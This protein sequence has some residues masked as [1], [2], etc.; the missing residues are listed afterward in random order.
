M[1]KD[2]KSLLELIGFLEINEGDRLLELTDGHCLVAPILKSSNT[3]LKYTIDLCL[4]NDVMFDS[5]SVSYY[6]RLFFMM[7]L[8][9]LEI[10]YDSVLIPTVF[11]ELNKSE[12]I[13]LL[14]QLL[15]RIKKNIYLIIDDELPDNKWI[16]ADFKDFDLSFFTLATTQQK[17]IKIYSSSTVNKVE[18]LPLLSSEQSLSIL[19]VVPHQ[20]LTGGL[21]MLYEQM[22]ALQKRGHQITVMIR[23]NYEKVI[24]DWV[25]DFVPNHQFIIKSYDSYRNYLQGI[26]IIFAG[27]YNQIEELQNGQVPV[28]YW[29]QG[30]EYLYGDVK[31]KIQEKH[32]RESL[33]HQFNQDIYYATDS[34]YVHDIVKTRFQKESYVLPIF[35]DTNFYYPLEKDNSELLTI[36]LV[37]NPILAFK[38][39]TKA[40]Q[41]LVNTWLEGFRFKVNWACQI[42]PQTSPLPFEINYF[43]N[44][45]QT[46]LAKIYR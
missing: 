2:L 12:G 37:G 18:S 9:G 26:D 24:P 1:N 33:I 43:V 45:S 38:G 42:Q 10:T 31:D 44:V 46:E 4:L 34:N 8:E 39:F 32:I 30:H 23:G 35:I 27:F 7:A 40:L 29:E 5:Q 41:V 6:D 21:K 20:N 25:E 11:N 14:R 15:K 17:L 19:Y 28:L 3:S 13:A 36:L 16:L 22:K